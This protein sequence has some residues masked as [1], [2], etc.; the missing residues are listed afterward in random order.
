VKRLAV[1]TEDHPLEYG[2][3]E[4]TIPKGQYGSGDVKIWDKGSYDLIVWQENKLEF[5]IKGDKLE[6]RYV[7]IKLKK[8]KEKEWLIIKATDSDG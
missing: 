3:F 5:I 6:G 1:E 2:R 4:G 8:A 7:L